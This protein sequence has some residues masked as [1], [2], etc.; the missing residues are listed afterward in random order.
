MVRFSVNFLLLDYKVLLPWL[1]LIWPLRL[2]GPSVVPR[3]AWAVDRTFKSLVTENLIRQQFKHASTNTSTA[4]TAETGWGDSFHFSVRSF[5]SQS[6]AWKKGLAPNI[7]A[8]FVLCFVLACYNQR[9]FEPSVCLE[10]DP[11]IVPRRLGVWQDVQILTDW[12]FNMKKLRK[13]SLKLNVPF[14]SF[15]IYYFLLVIKLMKSDSPW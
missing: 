2:T 3:S 10:L 13:E 7:C 15:F 11:S 8:R 5:T 9:S 4:P 1:I 14:Y 12:V 6:F